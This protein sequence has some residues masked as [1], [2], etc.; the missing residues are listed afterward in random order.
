MVVGIL[1]VPSIPGE[2]LLTLAKVPAGRNTAAAGELP[3]NLSGQAISRALQAVG[4]KGGR[5]KRPGGGLAR[6]VKV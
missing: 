4:R 5:R 2:Q 3:F 6:A 1:Q